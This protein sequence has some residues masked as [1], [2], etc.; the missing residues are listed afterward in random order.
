ME[1]LVHLL[2]V[3]Q[4]RVS[5][6]RIT[7]EKKRGRTVLSVEGRLAGAMGRGAGAVLAGAGAGGEIQRGFVRRELH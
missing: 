6:L 1:T 4:G 3:R 5:M 7:T 2:S